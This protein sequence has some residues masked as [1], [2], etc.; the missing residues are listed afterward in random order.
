M[1]GTTCEAGN[2]AAARHAHIP[3]YSARVEWTAAEIKKQR[4]L[5][6]WE[7]AEAAEKLGV[8]RRTLSSWETGEASPQLTGRAALERVYGPPAR[9]T[10]LLSQATPLQLIAELIRQ[11]REHE[12]PGGE[13]ADLQ[14]IAALT[15]RLA[16]S[17]DTIASTGA[18][19]GDA[20]GGLP[21]RDLDWPRRDRNNAPHP[22][23]SDSGA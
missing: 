17:P 18:G 7:Q 16:H 22:R 1:T 4:L 3:A 19:T 11:F 23:H 8:G 13:L 20:P 14:L 5:R 9:D 21:T 12:G 6:G 10:V 2:P 15:H